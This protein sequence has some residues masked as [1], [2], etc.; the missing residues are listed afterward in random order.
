MSGSSTAVY[1]NAVMVNANNWWVNV[2]GNLARYPGG[3]TTD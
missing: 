1:G 3:G 2:V